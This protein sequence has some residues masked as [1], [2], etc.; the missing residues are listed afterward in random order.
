MLKPEQAIHRGTKDPLKGL[1]VHEKLEFP[2]A[3][4]MG[5]MTVRLA[6]RVAVARRLGC[7]DCCRDRT[8]QHAVE[9][10]AARHLGENGH[11]GSLLCG[12]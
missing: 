12:I 11:T 7:E 3:V 9:A 2:F 10:E 8:E 4:G 1:S 5:A 6:M